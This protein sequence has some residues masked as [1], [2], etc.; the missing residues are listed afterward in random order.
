MSTVQYDG[1]EREREREREDLDP[2]FS[3]VQTFRVVK[4]FHG[5]VMPDLLCHKEPAHGKGGFHARKE[6]L[7]IGPF[8]AR[9]PPLVKLGG[10]GCLEQE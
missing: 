6:T 4:Y 1:G 5:L 10:F 8:R 3:L 2:A 9:K 7:L